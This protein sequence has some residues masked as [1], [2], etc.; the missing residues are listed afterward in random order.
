MPVPALSNQILADTA[1]AAT[2]WLPLIEQISQ[3]KNINFLDLLL[4]PLC[5]AYKAASI[6]I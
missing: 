1:S 5:L 2:P 4:Y 6:L 3:Y